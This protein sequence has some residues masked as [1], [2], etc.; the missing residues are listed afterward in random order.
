MLLDWTGIG[1]TYVYAPTCVFLLLCSFLSLVL[2]EE[3]FDAVLA[4]GDRAD[5]VG[6]AVAVD[7]LG[8]E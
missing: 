6:D 8:V 7:V 4:V 2:G 3:L 1:Q 5:V